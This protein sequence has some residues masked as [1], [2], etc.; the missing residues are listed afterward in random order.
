MAAASW[1]HISMY[2][3]S[4]AM[5]AGVFCP[6]KLVATSVPNSTRL[7]TITGGGTVIANV[8]SN[9]AAAARAWLALSSARP[10][11]RRAEPAHVGHDGGKHRRRRGPHPGRAGELGDHRVVATGRR[12]QLRRQ[13]VPGSRGDHHRLGSRARIYPTGIDFGR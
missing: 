8:A 4:V 11:A 12:A 10:A 1:A 6:K 2:W 3:A 13:L 5:I 7:A 9:A